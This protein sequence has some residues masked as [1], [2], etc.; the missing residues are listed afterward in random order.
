MRNRSKIKC[1]V[2]RVKGYRRGACSASALCDTSTADP[3]LNL[4]K[5]LN[6]LKKSKETK[7]KKMTWDPRAK[8]E[9]LNLKIKI[10]QDEKPEKDKEKDISNNRQ[11]RSSTVSKS[12]NE[13]DLSRLLKHKCTVCDIEILRFYDE[14]L[15]TLKQ[16]DEDFQIPQTIYEV[17]DITPQIRFEAL[18]VL[19]NFVLIYGVERVIYRFAARLFD[20]TLWCNFL[21]RMETIIVNGFACL[22]IALKFFYRKSLCY[23]DFE[24]FLNK[25][26]H[27][28]QL[29]QATFSN[30]SVKNME[31]T[32]EALMKLFDDKVPEFVQRDFT[33][34]FIGISAQDEA[35][36][37][38]C[39]FF[40]EIA[41]FNSRCISRSQYLIVS[42][43]LYLAIFLFQFLP[44]NYLKTQVTNIESFYKQITSNQLQKYLK[45]FEGEIVIGKYRRLLG[46]NFHQMRIMKYSEQSNRLT[47]P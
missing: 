22:S 43:A 36:D 21:V 47:F 24:V 5:M 42:A 16:T 44:D 29:V 20:W 14:H 23:S 37:R 6:E 39:E 46:G 30:I 1:F 2:G 38:C 7:D 40:V 33:F 8:R 15:E 32:E 18:S 19:Y 45:E 41:T 11:R 28:N 3:S 27:L 17:T 34:N 10:D 35:I 31:K 13:I 25:M 26:Q 9:W 4:K 12:R